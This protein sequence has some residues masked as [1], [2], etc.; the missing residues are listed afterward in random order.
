M[1]DE[2][3]KKDLQALQSKVDKQIADLEKQAG[4][5][6][7]AG[8]QIADLD[9]RLGELRRELNKGLEEENKITVNAKADLA[10]RLDKMDA[11]IADL[12][13]SI[14]GLGRALTEISKKVH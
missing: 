13:D 9:K 12:E 8:R 7:A 3:T 6:A 1:A 10:K 11:K 4:G 14:N 5:G 2:V